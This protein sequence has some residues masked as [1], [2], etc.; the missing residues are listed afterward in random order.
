[1]SARHL[2]EKHPWLETVR[3]APYNCQLL[4]LQ[5]SK[6][7]KALLCSKVKAFRSPGVLAQAWRFHVAWVCAEMADAPVFVATRQPWDD[8]PCQSEDDEGKEASIG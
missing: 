7:R 6:V 2:L 3:L 1:M 8:S 5:N 4:S